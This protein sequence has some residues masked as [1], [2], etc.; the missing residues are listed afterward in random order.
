MKTKFQ[1]LF[2]ALTIVFGV[3]SLIMILRVFFNQ[4]P[5]D[6]LHYGT[7]EVIFI[8][9]AAPFFGFPAFLFGAI[10]YHNV[11][12]KPKKLKIVFFIAAL[13]GLTTCILAALLLNNPD[14][15]AKLNMIPHYQTEQQ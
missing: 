6:N 2:G 4:L 3:L 9:I 12:K 14:L 11:K 13:I 8:V 5:I 10:N 1:Q 7:G 15:Y